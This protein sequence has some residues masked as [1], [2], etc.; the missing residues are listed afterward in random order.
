LFNWVTP[1]IEI[2]H[3]TTSA[4]ITSSLHIP[5]KP[6]NP[7]AS[8]SNISPKKSKA[9]GGGAL[10]SFT[11]TSPTLL[12]R[13]LHAP[14]PLLLDLFNGV[15]DDLY[16]FSRIGLVGKKVGERAERAAN[17]AW[18]AAT[19][20][21]LVEVGAERTLT[22]GLIEEVENRLYEAEVQLADG[23]LSAGGLGATRSGRVLHNTPDEAEFARLHKQLM[24]LQISRIKFLMDL[25]FVSYDLF[26]VQRAR[27]PIMAWSGLL[28]GVLSAAK[29]YDK[30]RAQLSKA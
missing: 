8:T 27:E 15:A 18:F 24:W 22:K 4:S 20:A 5:R 26:S 10:S 12:H 6:K 7:F 29:L 11:L 30:H 3:P 25:T 23:P 1:L 21:G 14:P 2:T 19:L 17:W 9:G 13:F 28:S 16:T